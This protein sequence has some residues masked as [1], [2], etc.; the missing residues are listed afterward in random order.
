MPALCING[1]WYIYVKLYE[2]MVD[3]LLEADESTVTIR[4]K[5]WTISIKFSKHPTKRQGLLAVRLR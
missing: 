5:C 2:I 4:R 3:D 1:R